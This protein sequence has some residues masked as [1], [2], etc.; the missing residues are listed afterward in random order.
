MLPV[1]FNS[2]N[3]KNVMTYDEYKKMTID[4]LKD[5]NSY[6]L[7]GIERK[8][9]DYRKINFQRIT[10]IEKHFKPS[11]ELINAI[12]KIKQ[13]QIWMVITE[14]WCGDSAQNLPI[15]AKAAELNNNIHLKIILR[16]ENPH[17]MDMYLINGNRSIPQLIAFDTEG[18]KLFRWG[19]RPKTAQELVTKLKTEGLSKEEFTQQLHLWYGRNKGKDFESELAEILLQTPKKYSHLKTTQNTLYKKNY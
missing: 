14:S 19:P 18:N 2:M 9:Y 16:D 6:E 15:I 10:R 17:I 4:E 8:H 12:E 13:P 1:F 11:N 3:P 5:M 7:E